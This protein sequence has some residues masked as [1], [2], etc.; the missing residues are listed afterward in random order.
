[1]WIE[2]ETL[3]KIELEMYEKKNEESVWNKM[4]NTQKETQKKNFNDYVLNML[5]M[6]NETCNVK[7]GI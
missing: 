7:F 4:R 2:Y 6:D 5:N 1:M 3:L